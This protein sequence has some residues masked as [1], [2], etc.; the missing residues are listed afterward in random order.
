MR[1]AALP[2]VYF[3]LALML[4]G[5]FNPRAWADSIHGRMIC[6]TTVA[7]NSEASSSLPI[8]I[9]DN[10]GILLGEEREFLR[11]LEIEVKLPEEAAIYRGT[12]AV[13]VYRKVSPLPDVSKASYQ[14]TLLFYKIIEERRRLFIQIPLATATGFPGAPDTYIHRTPLQQ[15]DF[16]LVFAIVPVMKGIPEQAMRALF[17]AELRPLYKNIGKLHV[18]FPGEDASIQG[19]K[20]FIDDKERSVPPEGLLLEPGIYK[21]RAEKPDFAPFTATV[22]I[23]RGK[24]TSVEAV[25]LKKEASL[26]I[27]APIGSRAF[28]DG[29]SVILDNPFP[30]DAGEHILAIKL[31]DYQLNKRFTV[32]FGKN[33]SVS[34]HLDILI[35][36]D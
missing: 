30:V 9:E 10:W 13:F 17:H 36:E 1:K 24:T 15:G 29:E 27:S 12:Y 4:M 35:N 7:N 26:R 14:G 16:P 23:D 6:V 31:G 32:E 11:G 18:A 28:L 8:R 19:I 20:V 2:A 22:G 3:S 21:V 25:F 34:L 5:P 33:Y